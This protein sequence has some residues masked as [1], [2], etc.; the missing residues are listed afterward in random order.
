MLNYLI[1]FR[2]RWLAPGKRRRECNSRR[3]HSHIVSRLDSQAKGNEYIEMNPIFGLFRAFNNL[4]TLE[5][6]T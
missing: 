6:L 4:T 1:R 5:K 2:S 3:H